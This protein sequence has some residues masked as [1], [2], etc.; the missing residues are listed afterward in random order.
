MNSGMARM[1]SNDRRS[2]LRKGLTR[3]HANRRS[4]HELLI[5]S[6][7]SPF[8][9][10]TAYPLTQIAVRYTN[11]LSAH[12]NRSLLRKGLIRSRKSFFATQR[13][14]PLTQIVLC[15]AKDLH[16]PYDLLCHSVIPCSRIPSK[17]FFAPYP[18]FPRN[19]YISSRTGCSS[20]NFSI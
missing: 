18:L 10:R 5:R 6:R 20:H 2:L 9:T 11:C 12:A 14:Y 1:S 7:K 8:V 4:L 19:E 15:Y 13:T 17:C 16:I 3:A